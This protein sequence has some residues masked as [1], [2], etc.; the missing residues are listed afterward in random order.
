[1]SVSATLKYFSTL[2]GR[3]I[4]TMRCESVCSHRHMVGNE[5]KTVRRGRE[6]VVFE[7]LQVVSHPRQPQVGS[8]ESVVQ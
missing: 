3:L 6:Q 4:A 7:H 8:N 2:I 1:M 5:K